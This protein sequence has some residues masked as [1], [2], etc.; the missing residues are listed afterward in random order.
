M[1]QYEPWNQDRATAIIAAVDASNGA[2]TTGVGSSE[3]ARQTS[4]LP[5]LHALQNA[6]GCVPIQAEPLIAAQLNI[7][8]AD[9][10]GAVSFYHDFRPSPPGR[11][12]VRLCRAE[13][14]Q[15]VGADSVA[16]TIRTTLGVDWRDTSADG[17]VTLEP[18]FC[19]GLCASGP[20]ALVD[21]EPVGRLTAQGARDL[22]RALS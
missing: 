9:V 21:G 19:L 8:R 17:A 10:H 16:Q 5:I 11:H 13:A 6:F 1:A 7:T 2:S 4:L 18:A 22:L 12:V 15:S 3:A 20:A 14:C